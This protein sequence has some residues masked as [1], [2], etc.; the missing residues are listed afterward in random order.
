MSEEKLWNPEASWKVRFLNAE[1]YTIETREV[2]A[3]NEKLAKHFAHMAILSEGF[4][5]E[6]I[7]LMDCERVE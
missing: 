6:R 5:S 7:K 3:P 2:M 4:N 1:D